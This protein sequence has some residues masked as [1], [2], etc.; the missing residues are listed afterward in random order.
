MVI[1]DP[2]TQSKQAAWHEIT[3]VLITDLV[4][5]KL[6]LTVVWICLKFPSDTGQKVTLAK[7]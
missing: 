2:S 1:S 5:C 7:N 4:V 3:N 6:T